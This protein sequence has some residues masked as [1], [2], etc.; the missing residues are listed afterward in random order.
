MIDEV[1]YVKAKAKQVN[2]GKSESLVLNKP[3]RFLKSTG[4][5]AAARTL[6]KIWPGP[7]FGTGNSPNSKT[8]MDPYSL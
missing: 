4:F 1:A 6:T 2:T 3:S 8:S 5:S 7:G